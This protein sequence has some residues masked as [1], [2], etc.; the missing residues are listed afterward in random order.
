MK[1]CTLMKI[2]RIDQ[3]FTTWS[4]L[5]NSPRLLRRVFFCYGSISLLQFYFSSCNISLRHFFIWLWF[6]F[7]YEISSGFERHSSVTVINLFFQVFTCHFHRLFYAHKHSLDSCHYDC[8]F[9]YYLSCRHM[10]K[11][12]LQEVL[13]PNVITRAICLLIMDTLSLISWTVTYLCSRD[14]HL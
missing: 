9:A 4:T 10:S 2:L 11:G 14:I 1:S 7:F 8:R 13:I 5:T 12:T 3:L 6:F